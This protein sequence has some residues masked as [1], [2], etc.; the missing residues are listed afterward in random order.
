M[1]LAIVVKVW[2]HPPLTHDLLGSSLSCKWS[3]QLPGWGHL[4][5]KTCPSS[6]WH[7]GFSSTLSSMKSG[8]TAPSGRPLFQQSDCYAEGTRVSPK[9]PSSLFSGIKGTMEWG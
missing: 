5:S 1:S 8:E 6:G 3:D 9:R 4:F 2:S 7:Q